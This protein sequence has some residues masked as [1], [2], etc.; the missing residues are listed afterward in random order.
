MG[1]KKCPDASDFTLCPNL[2]SGAPTSFGPYARTLPSYIA[3]P[4]CWKRNELAPLAGCIV[5]T[6]SLQEVAATTM[7]LSA[8]LIALIDGGLLQRLMDVPQTIRPVPMR[9]STPRQTF[10]TSSE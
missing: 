8:D 7:Q 6:S 3:L 5:G 4:I 10:G 9:I 1:A 2:P